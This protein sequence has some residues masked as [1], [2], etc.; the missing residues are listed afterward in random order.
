MKKFSLKHRVMTAAALLAVSIWVADR[1]GS[2]LRPKSAQAAEPV[3][4]NVSQS[5]TDWQAAQQ[6]VDHLTRA[7]PP[8]VLAQLSNVQRD[9]FLP[10]GGLLELL[11]PPPE[12]EAPEVLAPPPPEPEALFTARHTLQGIV[13]GQRPLAVVDGQLIPLNGVY[14]NHRLI[15]IG[16]GSAIFQD[17]ATGACFRLEVAAAA[18]RP[19]KQVLEEAER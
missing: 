11:M 12:S 8:S 10:E 1:F 5:K 7:Q 17:L 3:A 19:E 16:R 18:L 6:L 2:S 15:D 13:L 14:D 4:Q 9:L